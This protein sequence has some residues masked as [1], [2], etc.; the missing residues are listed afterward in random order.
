MIKDLD[1]TIEGILI[2]DG[3]F[4][5]DVVDIRF[6]TP[7]REWSAGISRPTLN[8]YLFDI[9]ENLELRQQGRQVEARDSHEAV[10]RQPALWFSFTYLIT[11]WTRAV[12]DEHHLL[13]QALLT[14]ARFNALPSER[15]KGGLSQ[16]GA[17]IYTAVARPD[18]VLKS[19]GEFWTALENQLKPS[20]S[21]TVTLRVERETALAISTVSSILLRVQRVDQANG[22]TAGE[23]AESY[24]EVNS[25]GGVVRAD[26]GTPIADAVVKVEGRK[27]Q[28]RTDAEGRFRMRGL[29]PGNYTL[30]AEHSMGTGRREVRIPELSYEITVG[31]TKE[32]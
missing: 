2:E 29:A 14:L 1:D 25:F 26:D 15:L 11:A 5:R 23:P 17:P 18:S 21:Y 24:A 8:C 30:L 27:A 3:G 6:E 16:N 31:P 20:L 9:R 10:R 4:Q 28:V 22:L 7:N 13:W 32:V 12:E 19:P